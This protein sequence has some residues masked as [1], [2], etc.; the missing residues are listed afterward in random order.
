MDDEGRGPSLK[1]SAAVGRLHGESHVPNRTGE[2]PPSGMTMGDAGNRPRRGMRH[3]RVPT[4]SRI[5]LLPAA[6][7]HCACVL[8]RPQCG[9]PARWDLWRGLWVTIISTPTDSSSL[10]SECSLHARVFE[11]RRQCARPADR[12]IDD[13]VRYAW[14][15]AV[16]SSVMSWPSSGTEGARLPVRGELLQKLLGG[17]VMLVL[18]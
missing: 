18:P 5:P 8:S 14:R 7:R 17:D 3:R 11:R 13:S 4:R 10:P 1:S 6:D 16:R 2:I 9:N 12:S 15:A